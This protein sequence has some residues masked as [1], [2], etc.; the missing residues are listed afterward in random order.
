MNVELLEDVLSHY[1]DSFSAKV[2]TIERGTSDP[3]METFGITPEMKAM[4]KQYWGREL[5]MCWQELVKATFRDRAGA[6]YSP[7]RRI[8]A[9]EPYDFQLGDWAVDTKYRIGSGDSGTLK[10]FKQYGALLSEHELQPLALILRADNLPAAMTALRVGGWTVRIGQS[11]FD[12]I[13]GETGGF[14]LD[15]WLRSQNGRFEPPER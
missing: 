3:L 6:R 13:E 10:K 14:R 12:W 9:D 2:H 8:G 15:D 11:A 4:N 1:R 7:P 5:G